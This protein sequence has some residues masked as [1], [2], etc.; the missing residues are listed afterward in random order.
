MISV[1][2]CGYWGKNIIKTL[3]KNGSLYS[4]HD[5]NED[6]QK[7]FSNNYSLKNI[8]LEKMLADKNV[9]GPLIPTCIEASSINKFSSRALLKGV[10]CV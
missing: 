3:S 5:L 10:P 2:G 1:I 9:N 6:I 4:V 8:S 7:K